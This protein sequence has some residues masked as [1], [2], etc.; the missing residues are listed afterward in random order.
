MATGRLR[1]AWNRFLY[2]ETTPWCTAMSAFVG[3]AVWAIVIMD[4]LSPRGGWGGVARFAI[5]LL[6]LL[7]G[8]L[9][10]LIIAFVAVARGEYCGGPLAVAWIPLWLI[11]L[12]VLR[13][14]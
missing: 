3:L 4:F 13:Y 9:V 10:S 7:F 14:L 8:G 11:T 5:L 2:Q 6:A 12:L 1:N